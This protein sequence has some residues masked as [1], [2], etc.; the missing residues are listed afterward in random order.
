MTGIMGGILVAILLFAWFYIGAQV[1]ETI[2]SRIRLDQIR[3]VSEERLW[4]LAILSG[5]LGTSVTSW[6]WIGGGSTFY[7]HGRLMR[8]YARTLIALAFWFVLCAFTRFTTIH[9]LVMY[10]TIY[11]DYIPSLEVLYPG[12]AQLVAIAHISINWMALRLVF[13]LP[14]LRNKELT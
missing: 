10:W 12:L 13:Q 8:Q 6:I 2:A 1:I 7:A 9:Y 11:D 4:T 3:P 5:T 14:N